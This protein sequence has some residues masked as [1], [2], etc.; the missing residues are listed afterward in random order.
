M[1]A[2]RPAVR[3]IWLSFSKAFE[4]SIAWPYR[5]VKG[6]V[7]VGL[8]CLIDPVDRALGLPWV[9]AVSAR[10]VPRATVITEWQKLKGKDSMTGAVAERQ[11]TVTCLRLTPEAIEQLAWQRLDANVVYLAR[12]FPA[13]PSWPADA[14]LAACSLA[15]AVGA[16]WPALY[17]RC[18]GHLDAGD[19]GAAANESAIR[20]NA[21]RTA[22][23]RRLFEAA[24]RVVAEGLDPDVLHGWP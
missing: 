9:D 2:L 21:P 24:A 5:D 6:L 16:G 19:F 15:W 18:S 20:G 22:V 1:S 7:T 17:P 11:R 4:G 10:P 14:Q 13:L 23:Q 3:A 12:R 8:G